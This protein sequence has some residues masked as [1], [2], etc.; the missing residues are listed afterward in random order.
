MEKPQAN[1]QSAAVL[2]NVVE[3]LRDLAST[4]VVKT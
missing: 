3:L 2:A 4:G 1:G